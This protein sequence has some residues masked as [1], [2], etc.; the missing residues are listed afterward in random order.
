MSN[1]TDRY[2]RRANYNSVPKKGNNVYGRRGNWRCAECRRRRGKV[3][4]ELQV[5]LIQS[6]RVYFCL[7]AVR[8]LPLTKLSKSLL[9]IAIASR[10]AQLEYP[11]W[12]SVVDR[13]L[14]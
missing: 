4:L 13:F 7:P 3:F 1:S 5:K 6:V 10:G 14:G 8:V 2:R 12:A 11:I 9:Q